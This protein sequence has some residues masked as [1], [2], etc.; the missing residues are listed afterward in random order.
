MSLFPLIWLQT[1]LLGQEVQSE[2]EIDKIYDPK[3]I[4]HDHKTGINTFALA[5]SA[6]RA[7]KRDVLP[8]L[9]ILA[10]GSFNKVFLLSY[11]DGFRLLARV[12]VS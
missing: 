6:S 10:M 9:S 2:D 5:C 11:P 3:Q 7:L 8:K 4:Y 1:V 12:P